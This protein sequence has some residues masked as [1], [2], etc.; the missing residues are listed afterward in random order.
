MATSTIKPKRG[1][2]A[3]W[4]KSKRIL[5]WNEW[6]VEETVSGEWIL[7]VGDGEHEFLDLPKVIDTPSLNDLVKEAQNTYNLFFEKAEAMEDRFEELSAEIT[8][9]HETAISDIETKGAETLAT[10]PEDYT[11]IYN[12]AVR[13]S[14]D[15]EFVTSTA[16]RNDK[17]LTNV[18]KALFK[19]PFVIDSSIAYAKTVPQN[20]LPYAEVGSVGGMTYKVNIGTEEEP[21]HILQ[22]TSVS[23]VESVG[24]NLI[25]F[26]YYEANKTQNGMTF[27]V[28]N[29][30]GISVSG[31][32]TTYTYFTLNLIENIGDLDSFILSL[33]GSYSNV[34]ITGNLLDKD[35]NIL[36]N[37]L[38]A[39][40]P[41]K[42]AEYPTARK[43]NVQ[44]KRIRDN[45][46]CSGTIYPMLNKGSTALPY[47]PYVRNTLP[48][49]DEVKALDG[50]GWGVN[51]SIYN[52]VDWEKKQFIKN[53]GRLDLGT[54]V[55]KIYQE[56]FYGPVSDK[57]DGADNFI[58][59]KYKTK[60]SG[61]PTMSDHT[62]TGNI[63][64][65]YVYIRDDGYTDINEFTA[66]MSGVML[67]YELAEPV[68]TDISPLLQSDNLIPVEGGGTVT[69]L[70][71]YGYAVPSEVVYRLEEGESA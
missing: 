8:S 6:G 22:H 65:R 48:I 25:S 53:V 67:Y 56:R 1:T 68:I 33:Y 16:T 43:V 26:P 32:P 19:E 11:E 64:N 21:E 55:W 29:D 63:S 5:E 4:A 20:A 40:V 15:I 54:L 60:I 46:P 58:C 3:Q 34:V 71:E 59:D 30:G 36:V 23:E 51:E 49:P 42:T 13:N 17:R 12:R 70:N 10:I 37:G 61:L 47:T 24:A 14:K 28:N 66:A 7:R 38:S 39:N 35:N 50:Y 57:K 44:I 52:Y 18:E 69:M 27:T 9:K 2:T 45:E 31:T 62:I 41:Y